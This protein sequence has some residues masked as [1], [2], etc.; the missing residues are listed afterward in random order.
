MIPMHPINATG[1]VTIGTRAA[2]KDRRKIIM[3]AT[4]RSSEMASAIKTSRM[5]AAMKS[6]SSEPIIISIPSGKVLEMIFISSRTYFEIVIVLAWL[7]RNTDMP[8]A[9]RPFARMMRSSF[10]TPLSTRAISLRR[11]G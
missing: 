1:I 6:A 10:S 5:D 2:L 9:L 7:C 3:T 8:T 4:T 11:I